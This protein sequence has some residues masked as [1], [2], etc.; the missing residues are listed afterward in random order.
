MVRLSKRT[1]PDVAAVLALL[2]LASWYAASVLALVPAVYLAVGPGLRYVSASYATTVFAL[3]VAVG[4]WIAGTAMAASGAAAR[5]RAVA[6]GLCGVVMG[7]ARPEG[8]F[9]AVFFLAAV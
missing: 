6:L 5:G 8:A 3:V 4:W 7:M 9:L 2:A 1:L